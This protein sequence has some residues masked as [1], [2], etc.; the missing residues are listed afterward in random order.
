MKLEQVLVK[1]KSLEHLRERPKGVRYPPGWDTHR[2]LRWMG[3]ANGW[4]VRVFPILQFV[5]IFHKYHILTAILNS[6]K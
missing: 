6:V 3:F 4:I 1:S 2:E 5:I